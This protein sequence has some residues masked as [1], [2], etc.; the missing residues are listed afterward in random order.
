M[1]PQKL[2]LNGLIARGSLK[3]VEDIKMPQLIKRYHL[4][5]HRITQRTY[6][7]EDFCLDFDNQGQEI[8][9]LVDE[10]VGTKVAVPIEGFLAQFGEVTEVE[11]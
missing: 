1:C 5:S 7:V 10:N 9:V 3:E 8:V 4:Y 6:K 2:Y 11:R